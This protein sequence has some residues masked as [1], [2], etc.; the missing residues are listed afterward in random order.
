MSP[1]HG[2]GPLFF[3]F[4]WILQVHG[5]N[6]EARACYERLGGRRTAWWAGGIEAGEGGRWREP[7]R[8]QEMMRFE[9]A[10][11]DDALRAR[12]SGA[13]RE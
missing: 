12:G 11:L 4:F 7:G 9:A 2:V 13:D 8:G 1:A 6:P 5:H 3:F 10:T